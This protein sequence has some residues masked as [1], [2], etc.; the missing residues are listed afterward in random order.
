VNAIERADVG[1]GLGIVSF[2]LLLGPGAAG[3]W[4]VPMKPGDRYIGRR[5]CARTS[6]VRDVA[7]RGTGVGALEHRHR[8]GR[9]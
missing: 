3:A 2:A 4:G 8:I 7:M 1:L 6:R 9:S 5:R